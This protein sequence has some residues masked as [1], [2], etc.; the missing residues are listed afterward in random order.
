VPLIWFANQI[1]KVRIRLSVLL[2][3]NFAA[4]N[5]Q[6]GHSPSVKILGVKVSFCLFKS[7]GST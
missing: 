5:I 6:L 7:A 3:L 1:E 2:N 4:A